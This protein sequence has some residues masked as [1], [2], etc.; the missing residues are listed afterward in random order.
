MEQWNYDDDMLHEME[1]EVILLNIELTDLEVYSSD[2]GEFEESNPTQDEISYSL[3]DWVK[4]LYMEVLVRDLENE[5]EKELILKQY[6]GENFSALK[7]EFKDKSYTVEEFYEYSRNLKRQLDDAIYY[8]LENYNGTEERGNMYQMV[9]GTSNIKEKSMSKFDFVFWEYLYTNRKKV[10]SLMKKEVVDITSEE[11]KMLD[12]IKINFVRIAKRKQSQ[13]DQ[14]KFEKM[15][16]KMFPHLE[17][18]VKIKEIILTL[19]A[20]KNLILKADVDES[21]YTMFLDDSL[22][23]LQKCYDGIENQI[24]ELNSVNSETNILS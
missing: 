2:Y 16:E 7:K 10:K 20:L 21:I 15:F 9:S 4:T 3:E 11:E 23:E 6:N 5:E 1:K 22:E 24:V 13:L 19:N 17:E 8:V 12:I 18:K 14:K